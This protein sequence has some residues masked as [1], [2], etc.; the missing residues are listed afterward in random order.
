MCASASEQKRREP[1]AEENRASSL[2]NLAIF[3][4]YAA[5]ARGLRCNSGRI[6]CMREWSRPTGD[7]HARNG[8]K[9][10]RLMRK[11]DGVR[12]WERI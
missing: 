4:A 1:A 11:I 3:N 8:V 10:N 6:I 2:F 12:R 7:T 9:T 5:V